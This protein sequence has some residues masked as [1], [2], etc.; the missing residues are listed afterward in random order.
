MPVRVAAPPASSGSPAPADIVRPSRRDAHAAARPQ[1]DLLVPAARS[2]LV[3]ADQLRLAKGERTDWGDRDCLHLLRSG[4]M[5][6]FRTLTDGRRHV[7]RF[8]MPGDMVGATSQFSGSTPA[9][10]VALTDARVATVPVAEL[11]DPASAAALRQFCVVLAMETVQAHET[12]LSLGALNAEERVAALLLGLFERAWARDL[13]SDRGLRLPLTQ[14]D[15]ADALGISPVHTNRMVMKLQ[16]TGLI[17][18][19]AEWLQILDGPG[20]EALAQW[21]RPMA[22]TK[23]SDHASGRPSPK[24]PLQR[25]VRRILVVEDDQLLALQM[26][27]ILRSLGFEVLGPAGSLETGLRLAEAGDV[28]AAVLDVRLDQGRRVFPVAQTLQRR[29]IPFSFMTGYSDP[30]L[31]RFQAPVLRKPV[32][33]G[34]VAAVIKQ[35]IH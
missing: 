29:S 5:A 3:G 18:L 25:T 26:Q 16:R 28:D 11:I 1:L 14:Q 12:L 4:W 34:S 23:G 19:K 15:I 22:W 8:L 33:T 30:E 7:L 35:L 24:P 6:Q 27:A 13:V 10:A 32:E 2:R 31:D 17:R 21:T 9:P 20:L